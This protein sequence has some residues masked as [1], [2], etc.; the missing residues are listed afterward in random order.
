MT[1][2]R[3]AWLI[4]AS[5]AGALTVAAALASWA[6]VTGHTDTSAAMVDTIAS[7]PQPVSRAGAGA[8]GVSA[9]PA[10]TARP[11]AG[12]SPPADRTGPSQGLRSQR[13]AAAGAAGSPA[14]PGTATGSPVTPTRART[15]AP[16]ATSAQP[17]G[18]GRAGIATFYG[19]AKPGGACM[20][21]TL[22]PSR[23]TAAAG[24]ADF[25]GGAA[26][27]SYVRVTG[28][29]GSILVKI[30]NLCPECASGHLD[31]SDEAFA[32]IDDPVKGR[33]SIRFEA[34]RNPPVSGGI[35]VRVK[36]GSSRWWLGLRIDNTGNALASVEVADG[37]GPFHSLARQSWGWTENDPGRGPF[38]VRIRDVFGQTATLD[39]IVLA[40]DRNQ[41][42]ETRP[43]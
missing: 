20:T 23:Y 16:P 35:M 38:R 34:V 43:Y 8:P 3:R 25:G 27:S 10:T 31:L 21:L 28:V 24:P 4:G 41:Q 18:G 40:P 14:R 1:I 5:G 29:R 11:P 32:A 7:A 13:T 15:Q 42:T 36:D 2:P 19:P 6:F 17:G 33:V 39:P 37:D 12:P 22:P 26:C 30:D 9:P